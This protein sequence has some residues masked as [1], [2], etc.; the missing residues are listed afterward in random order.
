MGVA[1]GGVVVGGWIL[2]IPTLGGL[3]FRERGVNGEERIRPPLSSD[4]APWV[5]CEQWRSAQGEAVAGTHWWWLLVTL[6]KESAL[7]GKV[8]RVVATGA[9]ATEKVEFLPRQQ[10]TGNSRDRYISGSWR[11]CWQLEGRK[12]LEAGRQVANAR[13]VA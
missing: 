10:R 11:W 9:Q 1:W 2:I 3:C 12:R 13:S 4:M 6:G 5:R 7:G 8:E